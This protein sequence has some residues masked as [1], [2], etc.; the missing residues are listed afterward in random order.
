MKIRRAEDVALLD[1][2]SNKA[3]ATQSRYR[4]K[5]FARQKTATERDHFGLVDVPISIG[6]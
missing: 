5:G 4:Q 1:C 2:F 3:D 6:F